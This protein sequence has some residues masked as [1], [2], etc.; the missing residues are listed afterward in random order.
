MDSFKHILVPSDFGD[1]SAIA[2]ERALDLA[3]KLGSKVTLLHAT[4]LPPYYYS[5]YAE[6]LAWPV[7]ELEGRARNELDAVV[8]KAKS[9]YPNVEGV[10]VQGEPWERILEVAANRGAD[11]IVMG[12]HGRRGVSRALLGSVAEKVVRT[13]PIPVMTVSS[14][15]AQTT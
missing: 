3:S 4:R 6:G 8:A 15:E 10:F 13:S 5:A 1:P 14:V 7:D 2:L 9:R 12:T 11:L